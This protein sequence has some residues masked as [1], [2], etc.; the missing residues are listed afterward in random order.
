M[1]T[2]CCSKHCEMMAVLRKNEQLLLAQI[3]VLLRIGGVSTVTLPHCLLSRSTF[4]YKCC[5]IFCFGANYWHIYLPVLLYIL[6]RCQLL[7]HLA[8]SAVLY[9]ASV[10]II[11]TFSYKCCFIFCFGANYSHINYK[12]KCSTSVTDRNCT[13]IWFPWAMQ[14]PRTRLHFVTWQESIFQ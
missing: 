1:C 4:S 8:I 7:A 12:W 11:A 10:P 2:V 3:V 6:L 9:S 14:L 5:F 13:V